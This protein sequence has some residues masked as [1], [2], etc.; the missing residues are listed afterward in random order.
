MTRSEVIENF[1]KE[2]VEPES[3]RQIE[4]LDMFCK[5]NK[6]ALANKFY[7][8]LEELAIEIIRQQNA[9]EK[10]AV[11]L[12]N[13]QVMRTDILFRDYKV[14]IQAYDKD[15]FL[16]KEPIHVDFNAKEMFCFID[17]M[18]DKLYAGVKRYVGKIN[19]D[20]ADIVVQKELTHHIR[21]VINFAR[22]AIRK[23]IQSEHFKQ[24]K[25]GDEFIISAG[26][27]K[28]Y[29]D[30]LYSRTNNRE[31]LEEIQEAINGKPY[32]E[33]L[34]RDFSGL[35]M[36]SFDLRGSNFCYSDFSGSNLSLSDMRVSYFINAD[37]NKTTLGFTN[38]SHSLL[39]DANFENSNLFGAEFTKARAGL[40]KPTFDV[41]YSPG[42]NG[43]VFTGADLREALFTEAD[44][45]GADFRDAKF[46]NTDFTDTDL[47]G[48]LFNK[49]DI[50]QLSLSDQQL[51]T[52]ITE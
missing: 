20:D 40:T 45:S 42:F 27:Y 5:Q 39:N 3:F 31:S 26:E 19:S 11:S 38:L 29:S 28:D 14:H 43:V 30:I 34:F 13:F 7:N 44:F 50:K 51:K 6:K 17:E 21:Y 2:Y 1:L 10:E 16:D 25:I 18:R 49:E 4:Q 12:I 24:I 9:G 48:A 23:F 47:T 22:L 32:V 41:Y 8:A 36:Q 35:Q 33:F 15:F 37:F 46:E 52:I